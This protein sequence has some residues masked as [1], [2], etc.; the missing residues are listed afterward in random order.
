MLESQLTKALARDVKTGDLKLAIL[1]FSRQVDLRLIERELRPRRRPSAPGLP[2]P[3]SI[4][5]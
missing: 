1:I 2:A 5:P 4:F 3:G